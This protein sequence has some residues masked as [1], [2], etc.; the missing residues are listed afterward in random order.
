MLVFIHH[1]WHRS[2]ALF[3]SMVKRVLC[4]C[5]IQ[6][7]VREMKRAG[8]GATNTPRWKSDSYGSRYSV[9]LQETRRSYSLFWNNTLHAFELN[10]LG[11][12]SGGRN[13]QMNAASPFVL[14][15]KCL[16]KFLDPSDQQDLRMTDATEESTTSIPAIPSLQSITWTKPR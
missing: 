1:A 5:L 11:M 15:L 3:M 6:L 16:N 8:I 2:F 10:K 9:E 14:R 7:S 4:M 13:V 12:K